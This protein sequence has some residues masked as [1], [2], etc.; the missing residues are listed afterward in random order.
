MKYKIACIGANTIR[1]I[2]D[3]TEKFEP[4]FLS[5][6]TSILELAQAP[7]RYSKK[8]KEFMDNLQKCDTKYLVLDLYSLTRYVY[9][10]QYG[11]I[12]ETSNE[13][14]GNTSKTCEFENKPIIYQSL[15]NFIDIL[16]TKFSLTNIILIDVKRPNLIYHDGIIRKSDIKHDDYNKLIEEYQMYFIKKTGCI[17]IDIGKDYFADRDYPYGYS[18]INLEKEYHLEIQDIII[19]IINGDTNTLFNCSN[20]YY[21]LLR[22]IKYGDFLTKTYLIDKLLD[23]S[24]EFE[25]FIS[26]LSSEFVKNNFSS[27]VKLSEIFPNFDDSI[28]LYLKKYYDCFKTICFNKLDSRIDYTLLKNSNLFMVERLIRLVNYLLNINGVSNHRVNEGNVFDYIPYVVNKKYDELKVNN[29]ELI[30]KQP[31]KLD[32]WGSCIAREAVK[33]CSKNIILE[34]YIYRNSPLNCFEPI[35]KISDEILNNKELFNGSDWR[36]KIFY[37][38]TQRKSP[39]IIA[40]SQG[41][42]L[43]IDLYDLCEV[44][45]TLN[46]NPF[47]LDY[48]MQQMKISSHLVDKKKINPL[49]YSDKYIKQR[50][51]KYIKIIKEKYGEKIILINIFYN[52]FFL[53]TKFKVE[54]FKHSFKELTDKNIFINKWQSYV[55]KKLNCYVVDI[56]KYFLGDERFIWGESPVH[57]ENCF[58]VNCAKFVDKIISEKPKNK[59]FDSY[60]IQEKLNRL[61]E[62]KNANGISNIVMDLFCLTELDKYII[63]LDN[64]II[65]ECY[66]EIVD[67]Y[68]QGY[69]NLSDVLSKFKFR[70][71][72]KLKEIFINKYR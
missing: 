3:C 26:N 21:K 20:I 35:C 9:K 68:T 14:V 40:K 43:L 13:N 41:E 32:I 66:D 29:P 38:E 1:N 44:T 53:N 70:E 67:I 46:G 7:E 62:Y 6:W 18:V 31:I 55:A 69:I 30:V 56:S 19:S 52:K 58:H 37:D 72:S 61:I 15:D 47:I 17:F 59:I 51:D 27:I 49:E 8:Q 71:N 42:W 50:L 34:T 16:K 24:N 5:L 45:Y 4:V 65:V 33:E 36:K 64:N 22:Y 2:F 28:C 10:M 60:P 57:Y 63:L 25:R 54:P 39:E 23:M 11:Y 48:D 12:S